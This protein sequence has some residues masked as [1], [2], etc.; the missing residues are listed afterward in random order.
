MGNLQTSTPSRLNCFKRRTRNSL[1]KVWKH[2]KIPH[3][4]KRGLIIKLPKKGNLKECKNWRGITLLSVVGKILGRIVIEGIQNGVDIRLRNKQARYRKGRGTT[5]QIF[6]LRNIIEQAN[7]WQGSLYINFIDFEKAFDSIHCESLWFMNY[8]KIWIPDK[9]VRT[10]KVF[11]EDFNCAVEDQVEACEWFNIKTGVKQ[12]C[13]M[14]G[15]LFLIAMYWIMRKTVGKGENGI[16]W[17]LTSKFDDLDFA[18]DVALLSSSK[19]HIQNKTTK[20]NEEARRV[21]LKINKGKTKVMRNNGKNQEK[22]AVD[23]KDIG[24]IEEFNYLGATT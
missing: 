6:I 23:G 20:M 24:E 13:N 18:D 17:N 5:E 1:E 8:A 15:F 2:E 19:E 12:V 22:V 10:V 16:R 3:K 4:W 21:G 11:Y 9:I 7:E 14:T